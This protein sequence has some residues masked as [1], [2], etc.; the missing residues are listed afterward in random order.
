MSS[1]SR[2]RILGHACEMIVAD[3]L[4]GFSLRKLARDLGVT[5]PAL[6][7]HFN[8]KEDVLRSVIAEAFR[9]FGAYLYRALEGRTARERLALTGQGYVAFALEQPRYYE[10]IHLSPAFLGFGEL[11]P[12]AMEPA[13]ATRHFLSDRVR[14][15]MEAGVIKPDDIEVVATTIW[16]FS[17]G[18]VSLYLGGLLPVPRDEFPAFVRSTMM[19]LFTGIGGP[20]FDA[21]EPGAGDRPA[22]TLSLQNIA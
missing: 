22:P 9:T 20:A 4:D 1:D 5:A 17:H 8:S 3:G 6:Y 11:P 15:C 2:E 19:R 13:C 14:E 16:A 18:L 7:R 12:E 21:A 10:I